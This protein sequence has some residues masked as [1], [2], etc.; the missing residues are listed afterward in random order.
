METYVI[1]INLDEQLSYEDWRYEWIRYNCDVDKEHNYEYVYKLSETGRIML[2]KQCQTCGV[3]STS[4]SLKHSEVEN[5]KEKIANN[6]IKKFSQSLED[7]GPTYKRYFEEYSEPFYN[8][9]RE[10]EQEEYQKKREEYEIQ[11]RQEKLE[12]FKEH[13]E[14]LQTPQW[15]SIRQKVLKRDNYLCQGCLESQAT[16][17]HHLTYDNWK[18][19][20]MFELISVCY[21]CHH[22]KIHKK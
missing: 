5:L 1:D 16:E 2:Y 14:Y 20:L 21:N 18:N 19:E 9:K 12:W 3:K 7:S 11:K 6:Q 8:K 22:N 15:K 13:S 10:K 17:V 4:G